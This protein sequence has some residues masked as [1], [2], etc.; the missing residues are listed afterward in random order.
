MLLILIYYKEDIQHTHTHGATKK[1]TDLFVFRDDSFFL[2]DFYVN[3]IHSFRVKRK[4]ED[5]KKD[6]QNES[7]AESYQNVVIF[8]KYHRIHHK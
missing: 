3:L 4:N 8:L 1:E 5:F 6:E 2:L 7:P